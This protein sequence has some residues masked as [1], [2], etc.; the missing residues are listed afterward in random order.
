MIGFTQAGK[1]S[2]WFRTLIEESLQTLAAAAWIVVLS[3]GGLICLSISIYL[4][5]C[6]SYRWLTLLY[7]L[8]ACVVDKN[9]HERGGRRSEWVRGWIWWKYFGDYFP[10]KLEIVP[11]AEF[12]KDRNYLFCSFPHGI[13]PAGPFCA[14]ISNHTGFRTL[15][16]HHTPYPLT[17]KL[18]FFMP[19]FRELCLALGACSASAKSIR[20]LL[21]KS[22]GGNAP[23]LSVG[24]A[25]E[26]F[27]CKP[28][29]YKLVLKKRKGFI[30]LAL[31]SGTALVPVISFGE[32]DIFDQV[33][34]AEGSKLRKF[35]EFVRKLTSLAPVIP[36][37][38][39]FFRDS[40]GIIPRRKPLTC[41]GKNSTHP[42]LGVYVNFVFFLV[43]KPVYVAKVEDPTED[44]INA[45]HEKFVNQLVDLFEQNKHR[46]ID[47]ADSTHLIIT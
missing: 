10:A 16:P 9:T 6:T 38:R 1:G 35:Q 26:A 36:I 43:G 25:A 8:W 19:F 2:S 24:G 13:I 33:Q 37:G 41:L 20:Y 18:N 40:I 14:F 32:T 30:K 29:E 15:L 22:T 27:Y 21:S 39:G 11:D 3:F 17:L 4:L 31:Q 47:N 42:I 23:I 7:I 45:V 34:A 28:G 44:E 12:H 5:L 46:Y